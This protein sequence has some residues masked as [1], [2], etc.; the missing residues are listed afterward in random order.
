MSLTGSAGEYQEGTAHVGCRYLMPHTCQK[1][2][3]PPLIGPSSIP[4]CDHG[5][6]VVVMSGKRSESDWPG[7]LDPWTLRLSKGC[8]LKLDIEDEAIG[9]RSGAST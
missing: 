6:H 9:S 3:H 5:K 4:T 8:C 1:A 2:A 7:P